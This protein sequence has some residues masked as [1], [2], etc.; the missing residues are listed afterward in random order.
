MF[1]EVAHPGVITSSHD[2]EEERR[3]VTY[4]QWVGFTLFF[5]VLIFTTLPG[6]SLS[7]VNQMKSHECSLKFLMLEVNSV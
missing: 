2:N 6:C 1:R 4:Y 3:Y 7:L 5:Q